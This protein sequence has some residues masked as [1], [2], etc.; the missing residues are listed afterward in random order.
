M[1]EA[2]ELAK[3]DAIVEAELAISRAQGAAI[4]KE[5][6]DVF[7]LGFVSGLHYVVRN[8]AEKEGKQGAGDHPGDFQP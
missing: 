1:N 5:S 4:P 6:E 3:L 8:V 2:A 7:R